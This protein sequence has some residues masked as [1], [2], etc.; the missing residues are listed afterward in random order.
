MDYGRP[1]VLTE[2]ERRVNTEKAIAARHRL[3]KLNSNCM[4]A[5]S[6]LRMYS[7]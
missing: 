4:M 1:P 3:L 7:A 2:E 6:V 5:R